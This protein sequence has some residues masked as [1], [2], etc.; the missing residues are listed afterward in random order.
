MSSVSVIGEKK[1]AKLTPSTLHRA[2]TLSTIVPD[3]PR[4]TTPT[5]VRCIPAGAASRSCDKSS[6]RRSSRTRLPTKRCSLLRSGDESIA[7]GRSRSLS[8]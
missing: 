1:Y 7:T 2:A 8:F 3:S 4:S 5:Y 6:S